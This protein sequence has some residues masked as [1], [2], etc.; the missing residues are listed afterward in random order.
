MG[1]WLGKH[2]KSPKKKGDETVVYNALEH[3]KQMKAMMEMRCMMVAAW[4]HDAEY[5]A[6]P[7][8]RMKRATHEEMWY[9]ISRIDEETAAL[10]GVGKGQG[11]QSELRSWYMAG[12]QQ[13]APGPYSRHTTQQ[14]T[15]RI[16]S[17]KHSRRL[18][19]PLT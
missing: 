5:E 14:P 17:L 10:W 11:K 18:E 3:D 1:F 15:I 7:R 6:P 2:I 12:M 13:D 4:A 19:L 8:P 9:R 16:L